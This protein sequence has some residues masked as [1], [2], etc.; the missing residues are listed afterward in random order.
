[1]EKMNKE[2][3]LSLPKAEPVLRENGDAVVELRQDGQL[4]GEFNVSLVLGNWFDKMG[5][6]NQ[7]PRLTSVP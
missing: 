1:M 4:V 6:R 3:V 7:R 5:W 2:P